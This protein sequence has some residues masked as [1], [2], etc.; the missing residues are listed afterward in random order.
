MLVSSTFFSKTALQSH[1]S[2]IVTSRDTW[3]HFQFDPALRDTSSLFEFFTSVLI[4][5]IWVLT[6]SWAIFTSKIFLQIRR[7]KK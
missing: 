5:S 1:T 3:A 4:T 7:L 2:S 6:F